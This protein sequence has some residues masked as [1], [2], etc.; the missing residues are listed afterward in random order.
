MAGAV[1][2]EEIDRNYDQPSGATLNKAVS[3][4]LQQYI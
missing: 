1:L 3:E 2:T 4:V